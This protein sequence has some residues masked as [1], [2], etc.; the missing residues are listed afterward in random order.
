PTDYVSMQNEPLY[1]PGD[2]PGMGVFP[3]QEAGFIAAS[4]APA[5]RGAGLQTKIL[6]YDHNWDIPD[7]PEAV[8]SAVAPFT[9]GTAWHCYAGQVVTQ[10]VSHNHYPQAQA[11]QTECSGG[12]WQGD[13]TRAFKLSMDSVINVPRN[14][15]QSVMLWNLA[16]DEDH[17]PHVGGCTNCRG[18]VTTHPDGTVTKEPDFWALGQASRFVRPGAV[19]IGSSSLVDGDSNGV[20]NVVFQNPDG[21]LIMVAH[22]SATTAKTYQVA[23]GHRHFSD[24]LAAGAAVTY[25]WRAPA[26]LPSAGDI[27]FVDLDFGPGPAGT[28]TGRLVQSVNSDVLD[29]LNQVRLGRHWLI[30]SQ[31]YG[32]RVERTGPAVAL[33]RADWTFAST[34]TVNVD[35]APVDHLIDDTPGTRWTSGAPQSKKLSL[36]VDLGRK[37]TF[38]EI[39]LNTGPSIGDYLRR[40]RVQVSNDG[41]RWRTV[42]RG[43]GHTAEMIIALPPTRARHVRLVS[44]A[45][46]STSWTIYD[47]NL[48]T[49][50][51]PGQVQ[52]PGQSLITDS[53]TLNGSTL[54]GYYNAGTSP[55]VVPWPIDGFDYTYRLPPT[56][57]V[58]FTVLERRQRHR[59]LGPAHPDRPLGPAAELL[60]PP[61]EEERPGSTAATAAR[62]PTR[63]ANMSANEPADPKLTEISTSVAKVARRGR[64][65]SIGSGAAG[66]AFA[67]DALPWG[68]K[69]LRSRLLR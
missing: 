59:S 33:P 62:K 5:L 43:P 30:Y 38:T 47:L 15:G 54:I 11:F 51:S 61:R 46:A 20:R 41:H 34:G 27:G 36:T 32:A 31:P 29:H 25:R 16:L 68:D 17:G 69:P 18:L 65:C 45:D 63:L 3:A 53:A 28:P 21:S 10:S 35:D 66:K 49:M 13:R 23:V 64:D 48:R 8:R 37:Q 39:S 7:Y 58:T 1:Q 4:L 19:R 44:E 55:A 56:A 52:P 42:A 12:D 24:R 57:A 6:A 40:Y 22:N 50:S 9:V 14:W 67:D 26:D 60:A 2:Y